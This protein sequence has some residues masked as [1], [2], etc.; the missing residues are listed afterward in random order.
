MIIP[1]FQQSEHANKKAPK[2]LDVDKVN[3]AVNKEKDALNRKIASSPSKQLKEHVTSYVCSNCKQRHFADSAALTAQA[4]L[5]QAKLQKEGDWR[6]PDCQSALIVYETAPILTQI[7]NKHANQEEKRMHLATEA[8]YNTTVDRLIVNRALDVL[9]RHAAKIG[10]T[11]PIV[12]YIKADRVKEASDNKVDYLN[13]IECEIQWR[14]GRNQLARVTASVGIDPAGKFEMPRVFKY[15]GQ[16]FPF[17]KKFIQN[18]EKNMR[19][20]DLSR[21]PKRS[22]FLNVKKPDPTRFR[23]ATASMQGDVHYFQGLNKKADSS[24]EFYNENFG[25]SELKV[26]AEIENYYRGMGQNVAVLAY[27]EGGFD[28]SNGDFVGVFD[29]HFTV[30]DT[31]GKIT[32]VPYKGNVKEASR[33]VANPLVQPTQPLVSPPQGQPLQ[34]NQQVVNPADGKT[35]NVVKQDNAGTTVMDP[36]TQQQMIVPKEQQQNLKPAV[37]TQASLEDNA[38]DEAIKKKAFSVKAMFDDILDDALNRAGF[39]VKDPDEKDGEARR[40]TEKELAESGRQYL[41]E[42]PEEDPDISSMVP[43]DEITNHLEEDINN[44]TEHAHRLNDLA[45]DEL[46][47]QEPD[48]AKALHELAIE[49]LDETAEDAS[50]LGQLSNHRKFTNPKVASMSQNWATYR[51]QIREDKAKKVQAAQKP[52]P[53]SKKSFQQQVSEE[54]AKQ[55]YK[56]FKPE[57]AEP[58][59]NG[60]TERG[61]PVGESKDVEI[62]MTDFP[63]YTKPFQE[64]QQEM[65]DSREHFQNEKK[66]PVYKMKRE[67]LGDYNA[68][69]NFGL[70]ETER[71]GEFKNPKLQFES[72]KSIANSLV[73]EAEA[74]E[75][76]DG[77]GFFTDTID[78]DKDVEAS[79]KKV[80]AEEIQTGTKVSPQVME[81]P[82]V[83]KPIKTSPKLDEYEEPAVI[84]MASGKVKEAITKFKQAQT[85]VKSLQEE[86]QAKIKPL[87]DSINELMKPYT[88]PSDPNDPKSPNIQVKKAQA[89]TTYMNMVFEQLQLLEN[90]TVAY[91]KEIFA[92]VQRSKAEAKPASLA[93]VLAKAEEIAPQLVEEINKVKAAIENERT[94]EVIEKFLYEYPLSKSHEKKVVTSL[95]VEAFDEL[96]DVLN[97]W[98]EIAK[99]LMD[100]NTLL[101]G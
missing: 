22:D 86:I 61:V 38:L 6:C 29:D 97:T 28:M 52:I 20:Q 67:E 49:E 15:A 55:G 41:S 40:F 19:E 68:P 66:L 33:K 87:Q 59:E 58:T 99:S 79:K 69:E 83:H 18:I 85:D 51:K 93:E 36:T 1:N 53:N 10:M 96:S 82:V 70:S 77:S 100:L 32:E 31:N 12:S 50:L 14:Y 43:I 91:E 63:D 88:S 62:G 21:K 46:V 84:E 34:P 4:N 95:K 5:M 35:Y 65:V 54:L 101:L 78:T 16:E 9:Q 98:K 75:L 60:R 64:A 13:N 42:H 8:G 25:L 89:V 37:Q 3:A 76:P 73:K 11:L 45:K 74:V 2:W 57:S 81:K 72:A 7:D 23:G 94:T 47:E 24:D 48:D 80:A 30:T 17:E 92:A 44:D 39:E 71:D 26:I 90:S 56:G 27:Y